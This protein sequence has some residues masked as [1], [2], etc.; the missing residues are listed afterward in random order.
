[1]RRLVL[2]LSVVRPQNKAG[3]GGNG[4]GQETMLE[5]DCE[6]GPPGGNNWGGGRSCR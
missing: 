6:T 2:A 5:I 1:M 4:D 3:T